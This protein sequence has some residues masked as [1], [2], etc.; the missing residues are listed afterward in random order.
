MYI[1]VNL[2]QIWSIKRMASITLPCVG[3]IAGC[4]RLAKKA[5]ASFLINK[6]VGIYSIVL[7][8]SNI[9]ISKIACLIVAHFLH[10]AH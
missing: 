2:L 10:F 9:P 5:R 4:L 8:I 6:Y 7:C 3:T 1:K